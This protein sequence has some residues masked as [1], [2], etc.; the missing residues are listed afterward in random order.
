MKLSDLVSKLN[1][2]AREAKNSFMNI[3]QKADTAIQDYQNY[4]K[5]RR[6]K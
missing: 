5:S 2:F 3:I 6:K 1:T 4:S